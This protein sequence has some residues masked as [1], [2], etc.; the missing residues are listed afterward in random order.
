MLRKILALLASTSAF[1]IVSSMLFAMPAQAAGPCGAGAG[2]SFLKLIPTWHEYLKKDANCD[3]AQFNM[4]ADLW[5]V[6]LAGVD[7]I[8]RFAG[9]IATIFIIRAGFAFVLSRG[10]PSEAAKARQSIID[11]LIGV[12]IASIATL[13][14][15]FLGRSLTK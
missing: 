4:P 1:M 9:L 7:I 3:I 11:A 5:K 14:V 10:N 15:A 2:S 13:L 12:V 6:G 8:L